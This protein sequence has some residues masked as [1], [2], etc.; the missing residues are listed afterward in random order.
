MLTACPSCGRRN[1]VAAKFCSE[2][3]TA[4]TALGGGPLTRDRE[5]VQPEARPEA[6]GERRQLTIMFC[7]LVGS[8]TFATSLDPEDTR[9]VIG[10]SLRMVTDVVKRHGG[11]IA[12]YVGDGALVYFGYPH[13]HE[14]DAE[15]AILAGLQIIEEASSLT[16]ARRSQAH[17]FGSASPPAW[18]SSAISCGP[19]QPGESGRRRRDTSPRR[20]PPGPGR[21]RHGGHFARHTTTRRRALFLS[22][23]RRRGAQGLRRAGAGL[24]R[25]SAPPAPKAVSRRLRERR[26]HPAR[27]PGC[28]TRGRWRGILA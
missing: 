3:G 14:D 6:S 4:L 27:R 10:A 9:E 19:G 24:P 21:T 28:G 12:R 5:A 23:S 20:P 15:R 26:Q 17:N 22:G 25:C 2:C 8:T 18:S 13:A 11:Y 1:P 7:D 16:T